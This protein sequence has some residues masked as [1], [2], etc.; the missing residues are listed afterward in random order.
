MFGCMPKMISALLVTVSAKTDYVHTNTEIQFIE[1]D[2]SY[3]HART[4]RYI[5]YLD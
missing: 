4:I 5:Q 2:H 3:T 1:Q